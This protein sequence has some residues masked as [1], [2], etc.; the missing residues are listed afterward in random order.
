MTHQCRCR[1]AEPFDEFAMIDDE[2]QPVVER[3]HRLVIA[4]TGARKLRRIDRG[5]RCKACDKAAIG[6]QSPRPVQIDERR[7]AAADLNLGLDPVL[8][9]P[10]LADVG[11]CHGLQWV[12]AIAGDFAVTG[13]LARSRSGHHRSSYLSSQRPARCGNTSRANKS[14]LRYHSSRAIERK[15][16]SERRCPLRSR[17]TSS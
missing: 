9:K 14:M 12:A 10:E 15:C 2:I 4:P 13:R 16:G 17:L 6:R 11:S 8:P 7:T 3:M 1:E 5:A